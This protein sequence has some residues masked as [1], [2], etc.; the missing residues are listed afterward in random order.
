M[1]IELVGGPHDGDKLNLP[2]YSDHLLMFDY[3]PSLDCDPMNDVP[4]NKAVYVKT[5]R[6]PDCF[7]FQ[8]WE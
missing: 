6:F 2:D 4:L 5:N 1:T 7:E 8:G 3:I